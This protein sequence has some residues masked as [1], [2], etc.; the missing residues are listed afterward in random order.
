[1]SER[2]ADRPIRALETYL[3]ALREALGDDV[4]VDPPGTVAFG[5]PSEP[6][7][8]ESGRRAASAG[9]P[10]PGAS[11]PADVVGTMPDAPPADRS[12]GA[13]GRSAPPADRSSGAAGRSAP[14]DRGSFPAGAATVSA[15]AP[16]PVQTSFLQ[17]EPSVLPVAPGLR[18]SGGREP[19]VI[20]YRGPS[21][22]VRGPCR[23]E[24]RAEALAEIERRVRACTACRL[25]QGRTHTVFG[26]GHP[27]ARVCFV[28]EGPGAEEDRRGEPFVG[29]AG[30]LL[31]RILAAMRLRRSDVYICNTVKCRPP[32]NRTPYPDEIEACGSYLRGQLE[33]VAP[34]VIVA[35]GRPAANALLGVHTAVGELRGRFHFHRDI[36]VR[37]TYHPAYLLRNP[38]A[39]KQTWEDLRHVMRF[40]AEHPDPV[41][42]SGGIRG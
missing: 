31:D 36:P 16:V 40:L 14:P 41:A 38:E 34:Q 29:R 39:K 6:F 13:A 15:A 37:V 35:L 17:E 24:V 11:R 7:A 33:T 20:E 3:V 9:A 18:R 8:G 28:G 26:V 30:Q 5:A 32:E 27:C 22:I 10:P 19:G 25:H 42:F 4:V 2:D 23:P 12:S 1:M 21:P